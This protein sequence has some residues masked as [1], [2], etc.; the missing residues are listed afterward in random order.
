M[1]KDGRPTFVTTDKK[2]FKSVVK[3]RLSIA[4]LKLK[5]D[6]LQND[7]LTQILV[8]LEGVELKKNYARV[9]KQDSK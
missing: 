2:N 9:K 7:D 1:Y 8:F 5:F 3:A 6:E 4:Y